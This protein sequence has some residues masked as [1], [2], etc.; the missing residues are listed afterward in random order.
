MDLVF[1]VSL[2]GTRYFMRG[3]DSEGEVANYVETEQILC[4]QGEI[5]AHVQV[6]PLNIYLFLFVMLCF[7]A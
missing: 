7:M 6:R 4:Y 1:S 5:A 2:P 3:I